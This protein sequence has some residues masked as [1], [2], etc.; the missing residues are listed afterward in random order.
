[1]F[2]E[3]KS[4]K[5]YKKKR[6]KYEKNKNRKILG[7]NRKRLQKNTSNKCVTC[8]AQSLVHDPRLNDKPNSRNAI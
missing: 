3:K 6:R 7:H 2:T 8:N 4:T 5:K 1:M